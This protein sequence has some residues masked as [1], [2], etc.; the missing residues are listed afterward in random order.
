MRAAGSSRVDYDVQNLPAVIEQAGWKVEYRD[1]LAD[2]DPPLPRKL[3]A[4]RGN[5]RVR[6]VVD[7]WKFDG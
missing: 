1:W 7:S 2:R 3:F 6:V 5:A 4:S